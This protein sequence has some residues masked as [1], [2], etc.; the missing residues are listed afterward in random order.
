MELLLCHAHV[1]FKFV[2]AANR[3]GIQP[4]QFEVPG[5]KIGSFTLSPRFSP[6][7]VT[8]ILI[9]LQSSLASCVL[10]LSNALKERD[11]NL[12]RVDRLILL[13][14]DLMSERADSI[15]E[16]LKKQQGAFIEVGVLV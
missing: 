5:L 15:V 4:H 13:E 2:A 12:G 7:I 1:C 3:Q 8:T 6:S 9:D 14:C 10:K 11:Q 16:R